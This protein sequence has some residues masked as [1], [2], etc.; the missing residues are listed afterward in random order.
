MS[1]HEPKDSAGRDG[2]TNVSLMDGAARWFLKSGIQHENGGVARY[3]RADVKRNR[4]ISTEITGYSAAGIL[5]LYKLNAHPDCLDSALSAGR[6]LTRT[7]WDPEIGLFPFEWEA[8]AGADKQLAY[9]FD[10]GIIVR[11]LLSL[12]RATDDAEFLQVAESCGRSMM[13]AFRAGSAIHPVLTLPAKEPLPWEDRW[14]RGPGCYQLKA[15]MAWHE[16]SQATGDTEFQKAYEQVL[17][18]ALPNNATFLTEEPD[19]ERVMDRLHAYCYFLE[20]LMPCISEPACQEAFVRGVHA[21]ERLVNEI[22]PRFE[23]SDV[24]AQLLRVQLF[25]ARAGVV[26]FKYDLARDRADRIARFQVHSGEPSIQGGFAFGRLGE[27]VIPHISPVSTAFCVQALGWWR[28]FEN[29]QFKPEPADL[30]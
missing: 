29:G 1:S 13:T 20:G 14:S 12:W 10:C 19:S 27:E 4:S 22:G 24:Q 23:R 26:P 21:V 25:G 9:F 15:A 6:F 3:Y 8:P 11:G 18:L 30:I 2:A 7:V 17:K 16:L 28:Q 5:Y